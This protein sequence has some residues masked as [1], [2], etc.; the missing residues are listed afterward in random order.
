MPGP[1]TTAMMVAGIG[2]AV[3]GLAKTGYGMWQAKQGKKERERLMGQ[4]PDYETPMSLQQMSSL[5]GDYLAETERMGDKMPG[6]DLMEQSM[7]EYA[8]SQVRNLRQTARTST[9]AL[10]ATTDVISQT[11]ENLQSL[12]IQGAKEAANRKLQATQM[13][14][15]S[16]GQIA[17][18]E[19][20]EW[21]YEE[22]MPWMTRLN[23]AQAKY[24]AGMRGVQSGIS[25]IV[26]GG[27]AFGATKFTG[28]NQ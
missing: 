11:M 16:L 24:S 21:Q 7:R 12:E 20:R 2:K 4:I 9:E 22:W 1:V 26:S 17:P 23:Q 19:E 3:G 15:Q 10:G 18:Y 8:Q 27:T 6:Q 28:Q 13:Y 25:N 14:G 5:Y